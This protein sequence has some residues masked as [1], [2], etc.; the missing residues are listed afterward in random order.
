MNV[1]HA[2]LLDI[3]IGVVGKKQFS[4]QYFMLTCHKNELLKKITFGLLVTK[5]VKG[6]TDNGLSALTN[7]IAF[8]SYRR[9]IQ[10][11]LHYIVQA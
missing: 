4:G 11:Q 5:I 10:I 9:F 6:T 3:L 7:V 1:N 8:E 2:V